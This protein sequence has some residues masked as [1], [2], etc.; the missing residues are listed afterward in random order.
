MKACFIVG[1]TFDAGTITITDKNLFKTENEEGHKERLNTRQSAVSATSLAL[2]FDLSI[3]IAI[4]R[5]L[6]RLSLLGPC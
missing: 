2:D 1:M 3:S 6:I 5:G 4:D